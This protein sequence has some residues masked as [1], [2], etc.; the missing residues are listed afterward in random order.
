MRVKFLPHVIVVGLLLGTA[1]EHAA[2][3]AAQPPDDPN[4]KK[5]RQ[6]AR[7]AL[8]RARALAEKRLPGKLSTQ[9]ISKINELEA[10]LQ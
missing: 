10:L 2:K 7:A 5:W 6:K 1:S 4:Q 3:C 9:V 8:R